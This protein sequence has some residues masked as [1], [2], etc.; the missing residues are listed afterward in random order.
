MGSA[1]SG[2]S[3]LQVRKKER[4]G[5]LAHEWRTGEDGRKKDGRA[6]EDARKKDDAQRSSKMEEPSGASTPPRGPPRGREPPPRGPPRG[7]ASAPR[8]RA[9]PPRGPPRG[10]G[11]SSEEGGTGELGGRRRG[12]SSLDGGAGRARWGSQA[13]AEET[14][15]AVGI[16]EIRRGKRKKKKL[17][18]ADNWVP[19]VSR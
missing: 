7:R 1:P 6:G 17:K 3:A 12:V 8:G 14:R 15:W 13:P 11:A 5:P 18:K 10:R 19:P 4:G 2:M 16:E 9:P